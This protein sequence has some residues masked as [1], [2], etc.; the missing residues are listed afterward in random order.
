MDKYKDLKNECLAIGS[1]PHTSVKDAMDIVKTY[2]CEIPFCPQLPKLA[3]KEDMIL[4]YLGNMAGIVFDDENFKVYLDTETPEFSDDLENLFLTYEEVACDINS[5]L[6]DKYGLSQDYSKTFEGFIEVVAQLKPRYAKAQ[7]TGPFTLATSLTDKDGRCAYYDETLREVVVKTL[8]LKAL[9]QIKEIKKASPN[10]T[11]I[12]FIDEPT[13][14]QLGTSAYVT[15]PPKEII[16][17]IKEISDL[18]K[19][20]G[21]LSAIHCCGKC[22]W[23][24]PMKVGMNIINFDAFSYAENMSLFIDDL[25]IFLENGG[26]I[27]WGVVPTLDKEALANTSIEEVEQKFELAKN[28]LINK[29]ID[30]DLVNDNSLISPSCGCGSLSVELAEKAIKLT[31][32]LSNKLK[33]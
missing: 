2:Y 3:K 31:K 28:L 23:S 1:L 6:L 15:I 10:T 14:S 7:I 25:K 17:I 30:K 16:E 26:K 4:Q 20:N 9:W 8:A 21:G 18:I 33:G 19:A 32:E 5:E 24:I 12:I 11:P 13:L 29:G 22:D 27:A